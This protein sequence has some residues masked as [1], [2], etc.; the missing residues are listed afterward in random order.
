VVILIMS[1]AHHQL[2]SGELA[3][4]LVMGANLGTAINPVLEGVD[5]KNPA[6]RRLPIGNLGT[7]V[8]GCVLGMAALPWIGQAM[9]TLTDDPARAVANFHTLFNV[10][11]AIGFLP[12]LKSYSHLLARLLPRRSDPDDPA[13]PRYLDESAREVPAVAL[14]NAAREA[15]R[16]SDLQHDMLRA[17]Q[18]SLL[19]GNP[20]TALEANTLNNAIGRLDQA[21]TTYLAKLDRESLNQDEHQRL[22]DILAFSSNIANAASMTHMGLLGHAGQLRKKNW[23]L[24]DEQREQLQAIMERLIHNLR[25]AAALFVTEDRNLARK[26]AFEK[27]HFRELES[28][29]TDRHL[30]R[31]KSGSTNKADL[32]AFY[33]EIL[34][35]ATSV[36]A[37]LVNASAYPI[38]D[39]Y[40]ELRPNRIRDIKS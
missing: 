5:A 34:R 4:A 29:A 38:L 16:L 11:I 39:K 26:L 12:V 31:I 28:Q 6:S 40:G 24:D 22:E 10:L 13:L 8:A 9:N 19:H 33:L 27:D 25:Q 20:R 35:D 1:L 17:A 18:Q 23:V 36:N 32:G 7:R 21:I 2:V 3:Y 14:G 37:Y 30:Q 15:L